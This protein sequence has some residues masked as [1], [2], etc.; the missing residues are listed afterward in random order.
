M[1]IFEDPIQR[2]RHSRHCKHVPGNVPD[3]RRIKDP[4]GERLQMFATQRTVITPA[5]SLTSSSSMGSG[6]TP[7][8]APGSISGDCI[9]TDLSCFICKRVFMTMDEMR[10]HVRTPCN[11]PVRE[12]SPETVR[13]LESNMNGRHAPGEVP[14]N[15]VP[16][17]EEPKMIAIPIMMASD[18]SVAKEHSTTT[19]NAQDGEADVLDLLNQV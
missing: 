9:Q 18:S 5:K 12:M 16:D 3:G 10:L 11:K 13:E 1:Q 8:R 7:V 4:N 14:S 15:Q 6:K 19:T 2:W 17:G